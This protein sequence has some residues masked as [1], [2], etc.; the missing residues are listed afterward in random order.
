MISELASEL[1][2]H[3]NSK[4]SFNFISNLLISTLIEYKN[5]LFNENINENNEKSLNEIN[6]NSFSA[7]QYDLNKSKNEYLAISNDIHL[8]LS[9]CQDLTNSQKLNF[10]A[11]QRYFMKLYLKKT[12]TQLTK[13]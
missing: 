4:E 7:S 13:S 2:E 5:T 1:F 11:N 6:N 8:I 10:C 3:I 9:N 12:V